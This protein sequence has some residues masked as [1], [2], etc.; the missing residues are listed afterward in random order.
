MKKE[1]NTLYIVQSNETVETIAKKYGVSELSILINNNITPNMIKKSL[2]PIPIL[3]DETFDL[4]AQKQLAL[5]YQQ[6]EDIKRN[7]Y[8]KVKNLLD[9][10]MIRGE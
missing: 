8:E 2:I 4:E 1:F 3:E 7:L 10:V 5:K 6:I 9:V